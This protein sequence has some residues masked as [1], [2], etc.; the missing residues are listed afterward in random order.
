ME[1]LEL[2]KAAGFPYIAE[3]LL[4]GTFKEAMD[5]PNE[6]LTHIPTKYFNLPP[7]KDNIAEGTVI[8]PLKT[9][10]LT[11]GTRLI[12]KNKA[13]KFSEKAFGIKKE[14]VH[15]SSGPPT[16]PPEVNELMQEMISLITK[17]RL[18]SVISKFGEVSFKDMGK[19]ILLY[20]KDVLHEFNKDHA[21]EIAKLTK[22]HQSTIT[23]HLSTATV[24]LI[25]AYLVD[26]Q[27]SSK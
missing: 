6:F 21:L 4:I 15:K 3:P 25:K 10:Y 18:D 20:T 27:A 2:F 9:A 8:K 5:Y 19:L 11:D 26:L 7:L 14:K 12:F 23:K 16:F 17:P 22:D 24:A 1:A 13:T